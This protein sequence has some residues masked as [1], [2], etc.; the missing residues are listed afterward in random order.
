MTKETLIKHIY[1]QNQT[2]YPIN[3]KESDSIS[4][5]DLV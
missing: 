2:F 4:S 1:N 3:H 5:N